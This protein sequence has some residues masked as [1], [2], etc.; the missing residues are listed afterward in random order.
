MGPT[1]I[2]GLSAIGSLGRSNRGRGRLESQ[3]GH[4]ENV[5]GLDRRAGDPQGHGALP[6]DPRQPEPAI[7]VGRERPREPRDRWRQALPLPRHVAQHARFDDWR[8]VLAV[9]REDLLG[10]DGGAGHR[11]TLQVEDPALDRDFILDELERHVG[12]GLRLGQK[13]P[14]WT[15]RRR[16]GGDQGE[17]PHLRPEPVGDRAHVIPLRAVEEDFEPAVGPARRRGFRPT[18][19][20]RV[21]DP[22]KRCGPD[23]I[24]RGA[25]KRL[26]I[27]VE[28]AAAE[29]DTIAGLGRAGLPSPAVAGP[30]GRRPVA[31]L[32]GFTPSAEAEAAGRPPGGRGRAAACRSG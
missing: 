16:H 32:A 30:T 4:H 21:R 14:A 5:T 19:R 18:R 31:V 20:P 11:A 13:D 6:P 25:R 1:P 15:V 29:E 7:T 3:P 17:G 23:E 28:H 26:P 9:G 10:G 24:D 8:Q 27:R 22:D 2:D 12:S